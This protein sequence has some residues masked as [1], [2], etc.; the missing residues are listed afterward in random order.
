MVEYFTTL[1]MLIVPSH[2]P[3]PILT[4]QLKCKI[5]LSYARYVA[6]LEKVLES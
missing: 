2:Q 1:Q 3:N 5:Y 4:Q 6:E